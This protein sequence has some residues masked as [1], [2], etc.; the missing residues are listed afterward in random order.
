MKENIEQRTCDNCGCIEQLKNE[1]IIGGTPS[2]SSW[3][4]ISMSEDS[5][6]KC[7][8]G[9][10]LWLTNYRYNIDCCCLECAKELLAL[11]ESIIDV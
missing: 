3:I 7:P 10:T 8:E 6:K 1:K 4:Q 2:F 9:K 5:V 11:F